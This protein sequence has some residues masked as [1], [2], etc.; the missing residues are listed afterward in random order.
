MPN[1]PN[2]HRTIAVREISKDKESTERIMPDPIVHKKLNKNS[3]GNLAG[4]FRLKSRKKSI[5]DHTLELARDKYLQ[6]TIDGKSLGSGFNELSTH[7]FP[8]NDKYLLILEHNRAL[9]RE[10]KDLEDW[11]DLKEMEFQ[12]HTLTRNNSNYKSFTSAANNLQDKDFAQEKFDRFS[13][14]LSYYNSCLEKIKE[15]LHPV[16][17][18]RNTFLQR[19]VRSYKSLFGSIKTYHHNEMTKYQTKINLLAKK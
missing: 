9:R 16:C 18:V 7:E 5:P 6:Q 1:F 14:L 12:N 15:Q 4:S 2:I 8:H 19:L 11:L 3:S 10:I 13:T 17:Q